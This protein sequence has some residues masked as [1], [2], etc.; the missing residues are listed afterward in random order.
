[1]RAKPKRVNAAQMR[2]MRSALDDAT[3]RIKA[4]RGTCKALAGRGYA[5]ENEAAVFFIT[6]EGRDRAMFAADEWGKTTFE[7]P[8]DESLM[9]DL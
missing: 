6:T 3:G 8:R 1:M 5:I 7:G 4:D 9:R 2:A